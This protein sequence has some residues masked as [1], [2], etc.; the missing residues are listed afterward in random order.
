MRPKSP[1][2]R[3]SSLEPLTDLFEDVLFG[4]CCSAR[5]WAVGSLLVG[6]EYQ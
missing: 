5:S 3:A 4:D 1:R 6:S 2:V